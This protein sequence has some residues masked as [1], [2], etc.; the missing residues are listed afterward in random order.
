MIKSKS[1]DV[2][3]TA[4][5]EKLEDFFTTPEGKSRRVTELWVEQV[6]EARVRGYL[7][8]DQ[9][10]DASLECDQVLTR[11]VP[12]DLVVPVGGTFKAGLQ[13]DSAASITSFV[14]VFYEEG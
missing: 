5:K 1:I 2:T 13:N 8:Q 6:A 14:T 4:G 12:V 9:I 3:A 10:V 7:G 11:P